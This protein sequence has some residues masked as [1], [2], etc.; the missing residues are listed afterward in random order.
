MHIFLYGPSGSGKS[1]VGQTLA[2]MLDLP[3]IDLDTQIE[4][5]SG[6]SIPQIMIEQGE[7]AF[8]D[9][10]TRTLQAVLP[11]KD[12]VISLGGGALLLDENRS[13]VQ[14]NGQVV[15]LDV[16]LPTLTARLEKDENQ[17]PLLAA[18]LKVSL[19][20]LL[21]RR[22][23]HYQSFSLRVDA[24]SL[25]Q[26]VAW[27]I[28][29]LIGRFR[30]RSM[31]TPYDAW[32]LAG[33]LDS[34]GKLLEQRDLNS[35]ILI[36]S[37]ANVAHLY[38][39]RVLHSLQGAGYSAKIL[40]IPPGEAHKNIETILHLWNGCLEANLDRKSTI[41]A[42]GGGVVGDLAGFTAATFMRGC[43]WVAV[44]TTLLSMV[45]ASLGGKTGFDLPKG[46]NLVGAFHPPRF[47]LADPE[48]LST[49]PEQELRS[50]L[51]EVVKHGVIADPELFDLC[52]Q[53]MDVITAN[54]SDVVKQAMAVKIKVI[55]EDPYEQG[56]RAGLN[57]GHT[58][59]HA[60]EHAS[61]YSLLHGEAVAIGMVVE[62]LLAERLAIANRGLSE[63][64]ANTLLGL[65]L[66]VE[67]PEGLPKDALIETVMMD[68]KKSSGKVRFALPTKIGEVKFGIEIFDLNSVFE[69]KK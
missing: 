25:P 1:T 5:N 43:N 8:R 60:V 19:Q 47:A 34:L 35:P 53:G 9:A 12:S 17:R 4:R 30:L 49:L 36:V 58:V 18:D 16:D 26:Q 44:P 59:G 31:G 40:V 14:E 29:K 21:E 39:E 24:S 67:I 51:A 65:G 66:P 61:G 62:T 3:F 57:F 32:V 64:I 45:D 52:R 41:I 7:S 63:R 55:E 33:G 27:N 38:A 69:E 13:M 54:L 56:I 11:G 68:K 28:Q 50:G 42:L 46:K 37:D 22:Q 2:S 23:D 15:F 10:E 20:A 6:Q 48:V